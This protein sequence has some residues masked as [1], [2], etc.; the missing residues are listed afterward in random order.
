MKCVQLQYFTF[1]KCFRLF[2]YRGLFA[3][4]YMYFSY[5]VMIAAVFCCQ[6]IM[7]RGDF[8]LA[9]EISFRPGEI[10]STETKFPLS[11]IIS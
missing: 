6:G 11:K 3:V 1:T 8:V 10:S 4:T 2:F 5:E 7:E 9:D